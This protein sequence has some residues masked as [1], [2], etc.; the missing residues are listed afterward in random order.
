ML[1][2]RREAARAAAIEVLILMRSS[3]GFR[4]RA[5]FC[6]Q[7]VK[8][9]RG[10]IINR[11]NGDLRLLL[12]TTAAA[13]VPRGSYGFPEDKLS[14]LTGLFEETDPL[15]IMIGATLRPQRR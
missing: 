2:K 5:L 6:H 7:R 15:T 14:F 1:S 11:Q 13:G 9:G 8:R 12:F 3:A 4:R 10:H